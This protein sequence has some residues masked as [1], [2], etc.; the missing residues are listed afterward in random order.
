MV[1]YFTSELMSVMSHVAVTANQID[2]WI[3]GAAG[4]VKPLVSRQIQRYAT[5]F[6]IL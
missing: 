2:Y 5:L 4:G 3:L 1:I 6:C